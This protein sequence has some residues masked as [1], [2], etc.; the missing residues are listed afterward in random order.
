MGEK[1]WYVVNTKPNKEGS[2]LELLIMRNIDYYCPMIPH[3]RAYGRAP[4]LRY[5]FPGY[6]FIHVAAGSQE[7][8]DIRW[9]PGSK[10]LISYGDE[11]IDVPDSVI[12][13]IRQQVQAINER[14]GLKKRDYQ[15]GDVVRIT[16]GPFEGMEAVFDSHLT[17]RQRMKVLINTLIARKLS[18][19]ISELDVEPAK[20]K[21][22][23]PVR[24]NR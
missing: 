13:A 19:E 22:A 18:V 24:P 23:V 20:T 1:R 17:G 5:Y 2:V 11:L 6:I 7:A 4:I 15:P 8:A 3:Q 14:G 9:L 16:S 12:S 10:R 21:A